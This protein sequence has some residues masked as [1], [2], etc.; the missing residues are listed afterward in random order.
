MSTHFEKCQLCPLHVHVEAQPCDRYLRAA[1]TWIFYLIQNLIFLFMELD[2]CLQKFLC[3]A[4][5]QS[6]CPPLSYRQ[7]SPMSKSWSNG[8][9]KDYTKLIYVHKNVHELDKFSRTSILG[10]VQNIGIMRSPRLIWILWH[11]SQCMSVSIKT[12]FKYFITHRKC[13]SLLVEVTIHCDMV[14]G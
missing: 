10:H 1:T 6:E 14:F 5:L 7:L 8:P 13:N 4:K 2:W 12:L 9:E 3:A 11:C